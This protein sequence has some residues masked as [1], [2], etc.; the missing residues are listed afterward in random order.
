MLTRQKGNVGLGLGLQGSG[1]SLHFA[2]DGRNNGFDTLLVAYASKGLGAAI[3]IDA[4]ED[5]GATA[6]LVD[7]VA[8]EYRWP[9]YE[10]LTK[11]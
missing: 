11:H 6:R 1:P 4:N 9:D 7:L 5:S 2:H 10:P 8:R 3:M